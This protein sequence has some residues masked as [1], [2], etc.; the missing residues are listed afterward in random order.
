[1]TAPP[2]TLDPL[3][4]LF[5]AAL[6]ATGVVGVPAA[7]WR[8]G[9]GYLPD[10]P[11]SW[12]QVTAALSG[13][14]TGAV[15]LGLLVVLGWAAWAVF[16]LSVA[17]ELVTQLRG[18]P[19]LRLPG[20][21]APQQLA[22]LLVA[23]VVGAGGAPLLV[24]PALAGPPVV[25]EQPA[26]E[27]PRAPAPAPETQRAAPA[28]AGPAYTVQP[29]DTL[30]R[31]AARYL[32]D[33][34]RFE[35]ILD[36]N[37]GRPQP[38]GGA[39]TD[40]GLV[41]AGWVLVLPPDATL[42]APEPAADEVV[43]QP[44]D[45]LV[46]IAEQHGLDSWQPIFDLNAREPVPGG[47]RFTDPDLIRP[48]QVLDLPPTDPPAPVPIP[49]TGPEPPAPGPPH[50]DGSG[51]PTE[52]PPASPTSPA[53]ESPSD[54]DSAAAAGEADAAQ[55]SPSDLAIV[56]SGSGALLA[57]GLGAVWLAHR[58]RRLRHRRPGR[59]LA[60]LPAELSATQTAVTTAADAGR[61]D[62]AVLDRA[63]RGLAVLVSQDPDGALPDVVAARLDGQ[64]LGLR[65]HTAAD[66]PPP[67]PWTADETGRWWSLELSDDMGFDIDVARA[68]LAPYPTLVTIGSDD[69]RRWLLDLERI[70]VLRLTGPADRCEDFA[71]HLAAELGVNAWSDL[72]TV[73]TVGFGQELVDL[74]PERIH[75]ADVPSDADLQPAL[76]DV[77]ERDG[78]DTL[79]GR[80]HAA[81]GTGWMPHVVLAPLVADDDDA[82]AKAATTLEGRKHRSPIVVVLGADSKQ[83]IDEWLLTLDDDGSLLLPALD[84]RLPA[85]QLTAQQAR[86]IAIL[87]AFERDTADQPIPAADGNRPWQVHTDAAGALRGDV[88]QLDESEPPTHVPA[89]R[90]PR[91]RSSA[92]VAPDCTPQPVDRAACPAPT[93]GEYAAAVDHS[94]APELQKRIEDDLEPLDRDLADWGDPD[95]TRP[96]LTLLGPV[97]LRAHGD[98]QAAARSGLRRRYEEAIAYLATRPHGA[99]VDEAATALQPARG[100]R[101]DPVSARAYVHRITA[102]ARAWLGTDPTTG[103]KHLSSGHRGPYALTNVLVDADLF[104]QLRAR[105]G[106]RGSD[107]MPDLLAALELVSGPPFA[108]RPTGYE[109]LG[110]LDLSL[111]AGIC[112]VAHQVVTA[113]LA[114]DDLNAA[115]TASATALLVAPDDQRVLLDAMGVAYRGGNPAEAETYV[116]RIIDVHD[117]DDEMDLPLSTAEA[118][119]RARRQYLDRAP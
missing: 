46:D 105:A 7:L 35:E 119:N 85:P 55:E 95:C 83:E 26:E 14:D 61:A 82:L 63:L 72:L 42:P 20:L 32:G 86:D 5:A 89:P 58:R 62:Y 64:R 100:G 48:G 17:V 104:R 101:T 12:A 78:E 29:R 41:R 99:T 30:G 43:V 21:A 60:P 68:R 84:L 81:T 110:G 102:G 97:T 66:R 107:G 28:A 19:P 56:L 79:Q 23:A 106:V 45:T 75:P 92:A 117:G 94:R 71:R 67:A 74:A 37:R 27:A 76:K 8:V 112:D 25:A 70:G 44:G 114:D 11:P 118:I 22:G 96:R 47:G 1:M 59:R 77:I 18:R 113:A 34:A 50:E 69:G 87:L 91:R 54:A 109:W 38:D 6:L 10:E 15:F 33:W 39:L 73:T 93:A 52:S 80:L 31:I 115:R 88:L 51:A 4:R 111:T 98:E 57:A 53:T 108:Q 40:P 103:E 49:P 90:P 3:R 116:A 13:P 24:A 65:L 36:L 9:G 2:R 16:A